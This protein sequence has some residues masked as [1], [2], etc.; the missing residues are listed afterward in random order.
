MSAADRGAGT[1]RRGG[2]RAGPGRGY[3]GLRGT[4]KAPSGARREA[5]HELLPRRGGGRRL[6][7]GRLREG[8]YGPRLVQGTE[9]LLDLAPAD[10]VQY[11]D[12]RE[13]AASGS[14]FR[15]TPRSRSRASPG[16]D[17]AHLREETAQ[18]GARGHGGAAAA[19]GL[20]IELY[21]YYDL[22]YSEISE[23]TGYPVNTIKSHVFR[24]KRIL[25]ERLGAIREDERC[26]TKRRLS[27]WTSSM[28]GRATASRLRLHLARCPSCA[29]AA[30]R[31]RRRPCAPIARARSSAASR[32]RAPRRGAHD[33]GG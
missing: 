18:G 16:T 7:A 12:Q 26:G 3:R 31:A 17:E 13:E 27:A 2:H 11:R 6:H 1:E 22:K 15:W 33:G 19:A 21:F 30:Q 32:G 29:A 25:R 10:R 28:R 5:G 23:I 9:P 4:G 20:C 24:A 8:L 14:S